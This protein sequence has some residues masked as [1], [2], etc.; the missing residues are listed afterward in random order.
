MSGKVRRLLS[1]YINEKSNIIDTH[2]LYGRLGL[3]RKPV[4]LSS[5]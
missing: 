3:N 1:K 2:A 4:N 5:F